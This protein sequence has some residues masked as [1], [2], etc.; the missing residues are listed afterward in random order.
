MLWMHLRNLLLKRLSQ[1]RGVKEFFKALDI[2]MTTE[3][4]SKERRNSSE[5]TKDWMVL[6]N[7][8][9][10]KKKTHEEGF[11]V[12]YK[13]KRAAGIPGTGA[14]V[15]VDRI[16]NSSKYQPILI[17]VSFRKKRGWRGILISS[18]MVQSVDPDQQKHGFIKIVNFGVVQAKPRS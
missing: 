7:I 10:N 15:E 12:A 18:T 6:Y 16:M 17:Q 11:W 13:I 4:R 14:L 1:V 9:T 2:P 5:L 8:W 3:I